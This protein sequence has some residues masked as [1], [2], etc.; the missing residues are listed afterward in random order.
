MCLRVESAP[1]SVI[2]FLNLLFQVC[3][4]RADMFF[5]ILPGF[6]RCENPIVN[7][8]L[9]EKFERICRN[10]SQRRREKIYRAGGRILHNANHADSLDSFFSKLELNHFP[11]GN[12]ELFENIL[13]QQ[14][15]ILLWHSRSA[16]RDEQIDFILFKI[17]H[18]DDVYRSPLRFP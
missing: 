14:N 12:I 7:F 4:N 15:F 1:D 3:Q 10:I 9:V 2:V 16:N 8:R 18:G 5:V 17:L 6:N 11:G 13:L